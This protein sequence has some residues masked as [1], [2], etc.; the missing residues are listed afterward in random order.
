MLIQDKPAVPLDPILIANYNNL[1][2]AIYGTT[3][4]GL[5]YYIELFDGGLTKLRLS[6]YSSCKYLSYSKRYAYSKMNYY[7]VT[8]ILVYTR[9]SLDEAYDRINKFLVHR[10]LYS[11]IPLLEERYQ[12]HLSKLCQ[13]KNEQQDTQFATVG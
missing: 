8:D 12:Y 1:F 4:N 7:T 9:E 13:T 2:P 10:K 6:S 11:E 5:M 3:L